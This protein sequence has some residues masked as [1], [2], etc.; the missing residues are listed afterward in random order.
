MSLVNDHYIALHAA[1]LVRWLGDESSVTIFERER[2]QRLC[3]LLQATIHH[4]YHSRLCKLKEDYAPFDP[5]DDG[6]GR[7]S[8][9]DQERATRC[10]EMF[11]DFD[12]LLMRANYRRLSREEIEAAIRSPSN[13][14]LKLR[15]NLDLFERLEVY[16]RGNCELPRPAVVG[17]VRLPLLRDGT[18]SVPATIAGYRRMALIFRLRKRSL[19]TD[20]LD[21]RAIVLK[22]FKDIPQEDVETLLPG[23]SV[24]IG[25]VEQAQIVVPTLSGIGLTLFKL[26]KGAALVA[27]A[28]IYGLLA[29]LG[30]VSGAVGYGV[31]S[32]YGYL[33][34]REK[35]QLCLTR[36][37]Y[38]QNLDNNAGVIYHLLAEA[39][40]QDFREAILAWWLL[41]RG[42][43]NDA[44]AEQIDAAAER[45]LQQRFGL[46]A[47]FEIDD[48]LVKLRRLRIA[49]ESSGRWRAVSIEEALAALDRAWDEQFN[50]QQRSLMPHRPHA[51]ELGHDRD[52]VCLPMDEGAKLVGE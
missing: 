15:F 42:G 47:D 34:T 28:G 4:E 49:H 25:L 13:T 17:G 19:L 39:E 45:W 22:L 32:F 16:V 1:D 8:L 48:A 23:A 20:P 30:L 36:H 7:T 2:F 52:Q 46:R 6:R 33:R 31:R 40:E 3:Q 29:F 24:S 35:H 9:S 38:F 10:G 27:F 21:T 37:L 14:G 43:M 41:W 26:L 11:Q 50:Y 18:R 5:D 44:T 12:E 51:R